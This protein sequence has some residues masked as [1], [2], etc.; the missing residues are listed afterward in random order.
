M[1]GYVRSFSRVN[2][3][4]IQAPDFVNEFTAVD[5]A[6]NAATGHTHDGTAGGGTYVPLIADTANL[7]SLVVDNINSQIVA[8]VNVAGI[9]TEQFRIGNGVLLPTVSNTIDIGSTGQKFKD[10]HL[11]GTVDMGSLTLGLI[12]VTEILNDSAMTANS[13]TALVTQAS[14]KAYADYTQSLADSYTNTIIGTHKHDGTNSVIIQEIGTTDGNN[15]ILVAPGTITFSTYNGVAKVDQVILDLNVL[16]P[17]ANAGAD[18]GNT[19]YRYSNGYINN[20]NGQQLLLSGLPSGQVLQVVGNTGSYAVA[21]TNASTTLNQNYGIQINAG[22]SSTDAALYV[23]K[24]DGTIRFFVVNGDGSLVIGPNTVASNGAG[25]L[26]VQNG[27]YV[28]ATTVA[29]TT[30]LANYLPLTGGTLTGGETITPSAGVALTLNGI[31][32][33]NTALLT[34]GATA[35]SSLGLQINAGTT[36]ADYA[37]LIKNQTALTNYLEVFGDGGVVLGAAT[38]GDLGLGTLNTTGLYVNGTAVA[39]GSFLSLTG[40]TLTGATTITPTSAVIPLTLN[41][42]TNYAMNINGGSVANSSYGIRIN[43]GTSSTDGPLLVYNGSVA[44]ILAQIHGDGGMTLA[45]P[46]GGDKGLG[47]LNATGVYVN[48]IAAATVTTW[49][50][51][52]SGGVIMARLSGTDLYITNNGVAP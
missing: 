40:G 50:G 21:V 2:G 37:L 42:T 38:G 27:I 6:F 9:K 4:L 14:A 47:T 51:S 20:M 5:A 41:P 48:N 31:A 35:G 32:A 23:G 26:T 18:L 7:T 25:T 19:T 39:V 15:L 29:L 13:A 44:T 46:T 49:A 17:V 8:S 30:D 52:T 43:A 16:R 34:G 24:H 3:D 11:S 22:S 45:A 33:S 12:T 1:T 28:G 36:N 10:L